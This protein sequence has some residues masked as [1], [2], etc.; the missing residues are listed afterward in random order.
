MLLEYSMRVNN[1]LT[2]K[3]CVCYLVELVDHK[4]QDHDYEELD[5]LPIKY[6]LK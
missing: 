3:K 5:H 1:K 4:V 6:R 2:S